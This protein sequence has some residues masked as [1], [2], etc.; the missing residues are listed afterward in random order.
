MALQANG[1][2]SLTQV[3]TEFGGTAPH[4]MSEY[5]GV[6]TGVPTVGSAIGLGNFYNKASRFVATITT[7][8]KELNLYTWLTSIGWDQN[9]KV[10][11][12][13]NSGVYV[14]S[15]NTAAPA[16]NMGGSFPRG[17]EI[18]NNGFIM[19]RG[20]DGGYVNSL[21]AV[22]S[23]RPLFQA[24][25]GGPAINITGPVTINNTN[26]YIGGGG[27]GGGGKAQ[28]EGS[29]VPYGDCAGGGGAGGGNGGHAIVSNLIGSTTVL[30]FS[31][32]GLGGAIG[33]NGTYSYVVTSTTITGQVLWP[34]THSGAGGS[35]GAAWIPVKSSYGFFVS[36]VGGGRIMPG[37][38]RGTA[39]VFSLFPLGNLSAATFT[40]DR[41]NSA[42][43]AAYPNSNDA[44]GVNS[45]EHGTPGGAPNTPGINTLDFGMQVVVGSLSPV[46][47]PQA[48]SGGGWGAK[49]GD[50]HG[51]TPGGTAAAGVSFGLGGAGGKA[52]NTNGHTVTFAGG[53]DRVYGV[54]G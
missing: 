15:D 39:G 19:G 30:S 47:Y 45:V 42:L 36:G 32:L 11:L 4:Q 16:L 35:S 1:T 48:G 9:R 53:S 28:G 49:G 24:T 54:V 46:Y 34:G 29:L 17:L 26:G 21:S 27:G 40:P 5:Y 2:I 41:R 37:V 23:G 51:A 50:A 6:D 44:L 31:G 52:I 12:T 43:A 13:I 14:W 22:A 10:E 33:Q 38:Y 3:A 20:G 7:S 18:T 25:A 8:V